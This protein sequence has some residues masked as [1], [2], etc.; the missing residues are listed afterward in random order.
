MN[1][2]D[3]EDLL[4]KIDYDLGDEITLYCPKC[5]KKITVAHLEWSALICIHCKKEITKNQFLIYLS[6]LYANLHNLVTNLYN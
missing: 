3:V 5:I 4:D 1:K 6:E 2:K